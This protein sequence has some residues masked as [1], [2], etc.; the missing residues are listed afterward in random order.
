MAGGEVVSAA[1][2]SPPASA[3]VDDELFRIE[4]RGLEPVPDEHR[5]GHPVELFFIWAAALADFF[6]FFAGAILVGLGLGVVDAAIVLASGAL[7]GA[8]LLGP[9]SVT[10]VRTGLPQI[11]YSRIAFGRTGAAIGGLLTALIAIGWFA[12]DCAIAVDT[13]KALPVF[14]AGPPTWLVALMLGGMVCGCIAV[15]V[16]GHRTISVVEAVQ[17]PAFIAICAGIAAVLW[18]RFHL[19]LRS[20]LPPAEHVAVALFGFTATFALIVSWA[21][22][23]ADYSRYLPRTSS[24]WAV[25]LWSGGGSVVT[26]VL[27][28]LLGIAVQSIDPRNQ[29]I[30]GLIVG[31]LPTW[32]AWVFVAFIVVAEMSSNYLNIYTAALSGLAVGL[33]MRRWRAAL[34]VGLV[35]GGFAGWILVHG[36]FQTTYVNFLT[37]TYVWFPAWCIVVLVDFWRRR[38]RVDA[39]LA[40]V[41]RRPWWR[42]VRWPALVAFLGGTAATALFYNARANQSFAGPLAAWIFRG[43]TASADVSSIVG[44][45][46][47]LALFVVLLRR[48]PQPMRPT[49]LAST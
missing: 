6:S 40:L 2:A 32:F 46:A 22:Y 31:G 38:G 36:D 27:C 43:A 12:Y 30:A 13:A 44:V 42:D 9:L 35:G 5:H 25:S 7:A 15:A 41:A 14:G 24:A 49:S 16:W 8:A 26:L 29:D 19:G 17:A 20:S 28:G 3:A 23:A 11:M 4:R 10:G 33:P 45:V 21:T 1:S 34:V 18:P 48:R 47:S 39:A 37:A